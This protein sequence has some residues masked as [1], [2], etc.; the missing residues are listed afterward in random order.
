MI[1]VNQSIGRLNRTKQIILSVVI[2]LLL[3]TGLL[4]VTQRS[5]SRLT[6]K[7][8]SYVSQ[9]TFSRDGNFL[10]T[11]APVGAGMLVTLWDS[12]KGQ[13]IKE[14]TLDY[15][16]RDFAISPTAGRVTLL[17]EENTL[18]TLDMVSLETKDNID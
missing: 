18:V 2:L 12:Y 3:L 7:L 16:V 14:R 1:S 10:L 17:T 6:W 4:I 8:P 13:K 5:G 11:D 15:Q 9:A